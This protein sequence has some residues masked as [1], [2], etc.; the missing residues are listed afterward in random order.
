[1]EF[2]TDDNFLIFCAKHYENCYSTDEFFEDL[3]RLKYIKKLVTIFQKSGKLQERL[4]LNHIIVLNNVF[5]P[6]ALNKMLFL[7]L[8]DQMPYIKPFLLLLDILPEKV[9]GVGTEQVIHTDV[10]EMNNVVIEA[11]RKI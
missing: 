3:Q 2:V 10:I 11:L 6:E 4:I 5:G 8:R 9:Y 1:M 7:K